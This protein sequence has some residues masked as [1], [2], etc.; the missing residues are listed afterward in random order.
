VLAKNLSDFLTASALEDPAGSDALDAGVQLAEVLA[1]GA[2][3]LH[4]DPRARDGIV[5]L[6]SRNQT[7]FTLPALETDSPEALFSLWSEVGASVLRRM[8]AIAVLLHEAAQTSD[9]QVMSRRLEHG[10]NAAVAALAR[11]LADEHTGDRVRRTSVLISDARARLRE[12]IEDSA[13]DVELPLLRAFH[14]GVLVWAVGLGLCAE[15]AGHT[16][17]QRLRPGLIADAVDFVASGAR[18]AGYFAA[19]SAGLQVGDEAPDELQPFLSN[20][21]AVAFLLRATNEIPRAFGPEAR[22]RLEFF[23]YPDAPTESEYHVVIDSP[24]PVDEASAR[25]DRLC[26]DWWDDAA[27]SLDVYAVLGVIEND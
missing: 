20:D 12:L 3:V 10:D 14:R 27:A 8:D 13:A 2:S 22:Y 6:A 5:F 17:D 7:E 4:L 26:D 19:I 21:D 23:R 16:S 24:L 25:L 18:L 9:S 1:L 11:K 15:I